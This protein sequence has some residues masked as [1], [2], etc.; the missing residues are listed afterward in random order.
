M[1][2]YDQIVFSQVLDFDQ[3]KKILKS[4]QAPLI[5]KKKIYQYKGKN[6]TPLKQLKNQMKRL[7][8]RPLLEVLR[9]KNL[10][11]MHKKILNHQI[12]DLPK[13]LEHMEGDI[14]LKIKKNENQHKHQ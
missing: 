10:N 13:E 8:M 14:L 1:S 5:T 12:A 4:L 2:F 11:N 6:R 9:K 3:N 7:V